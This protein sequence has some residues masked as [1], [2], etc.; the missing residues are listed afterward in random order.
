MGCS[1]SQEAP[2]WAHLEPVAALAVDC[3]STHGGWVGGVAVGEGRVFGCSHS[4]TNDN[5]D[6][7]PVV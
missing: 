5:D 4:H 2:A 6:V 1:H 7:P 3:P